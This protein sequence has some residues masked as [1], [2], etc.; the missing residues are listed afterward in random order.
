MSSTMKPPPAAPPGDGGDGENGRGSQPSAQ[1]RIAG[2]SGIMMAGILASRLLGLVRERVIAHQFGQG[3][4]TDVYNGAF[5][6]PDL[7]FFLIAGGALSGAFIPVF[8]DY[9]STDRKKDAWRIF[10]VVASVMTIVV[11]IAI[12]IGMVFTHQLV[13]MTNPGFAE[14]PGKVEATVQLT[15]ILLPAQLCFFLGGLM[16]GTLTSRGF[17]FGQAVGPIIY[18]LFIILGGLFLAPS[19]GVAGL[20]WGAVAGAV[21]GNLVLQWVLVRRTGG[22]FVSGSLKTHFRHAG[23]IKVWHLM[24]PV[25]LGLALPQVSTIIGKA[26]ASVLGDGPQSALVNANKLMQVPL[27][28]FAQAIAIASLPTMAAQAAQQ[29]FAALRQT[30]N[31]SLRSILFLT[32][33]SSILMFVLA[34]P[35]VQLLLQ[36]G[37]FSQADAEVAA[38]ALRYFAVGIFAWSAHSIVTR[39]FYALQ[40]SRTP[41]IVG[42]VVTFI[43]IPLN[44]LSLRLTGTKDPAMAVAGLAAVTSIAASIHML[45]MIVLLRRRLRGI[46]GGRLLVSIGKITLASLLTALIC[47]L[48]RDGLQ[49]HFVPPLLS[50]GQTTHHVTRE[51]ALVLGVCLLVSTVVYLSLAIL[52]RMEEAQILH[53]LRRK[54]FRR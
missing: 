6:I 1:R 19:M 4:D 41:I 34:L 30:V 22:Y 52:F 13:R 38:A 2:A 17:F 26:Y 7:L 40:E 5:T 14:V 10:S 31:F 21:V 39:G 42:T 11:S 44:A 43:F 24:L 54:L 46:E 18:N 16:M 20:C 8:T 12:L 3:F 47:R 33:P 32:I 37:K 49:S 53:R 25:I 29:Q 36:S 9:I 28:V 27:G 15:R 50:P 35:I 23:V 45:S 51:S 48:V